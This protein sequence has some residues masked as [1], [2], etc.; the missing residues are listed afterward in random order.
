ATDASSS[1][2]PSSLVTNW[3]K[4]FDKW[5]GRASQP[6]RVVVRS[7]DGA[8]LSALRS[9]VPLKPNVAEVLILSYELFRLH[10]KIVS[11]AGKV[12]LLVV[13]EGHRLKNTAGSQILTALESVR[14][15]ARILITG[16]PIQRVLERRELRSPRRARV[17]VRLPP[18]LRAADGAG[19]PEERERGREGEGTAAVEGARGRHVDLRP[20]PT[21]EGRPPDAP[22]A[23]VGGAPVLPADARQRELY[24]DVARRASRSI[25]GVP[26]GIGDGGGGGTTR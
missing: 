21:P 13:D 5:L 7:G 10:A 26:G 1:C 25:G 3:A 11:R 19:Q 14:A 12:G 16:T 24:L 4:E 2:V 9:F 15:D 6:R 8:G 20:P 22:A 17:A 23:A 18:P